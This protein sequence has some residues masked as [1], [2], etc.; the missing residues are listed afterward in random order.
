MQ[1]PLPAGLVPAMDY[2]TTINFKTA[3]Q[4][5]KNTRPLIAHGVHG[6]A[7]INDFFY[8]FT[9][10]DCFYRSVFCLTED[11]FNELKKGVRYVIHSF[12]K[13]HQ[14]NDFNAIG[15]FPSKKFNFRIINFSGGKLCQI[16]FK[17]NTL[18]FHEDWLKDLLKCLTM[19]PA[20]PTA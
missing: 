7:Y 15:I 18:T 6:V 13:H 11:E 8:I 2:E 3:T 19:Q 12:K 1:E 5:Y 20:E 16:E 9:E 17:E 4:K 14:I 10:D